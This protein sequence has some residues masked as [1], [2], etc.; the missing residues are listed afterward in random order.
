MKK[1]AKRASAKKHRARSARAK[2]VDRIPTG[3]PHFDA[4]IEG[5][6]EKR[7]TN[8]IVG[9]PGSGKSILA[10]Q[11][12][13]N[14]MMRGEHCLYITFEERKDE[15]YRNMLRFGWDL[16]EYEKRGLFTFLEYTPSKVR[17][18]LEEGGGII[19]SIV[20][21]KKVTRIVIDSIT[22][23]V[24][25]FEDELAKREASLKLFNMVSNWNCTSFLTLETN[26]AEKEKLDAR[27]MEFETDSIILLYFIRSTT[28]RERYLEVLKMRGTRHSK[29]MYRFHITDRGIVV[30]SSPRTKPPQAIR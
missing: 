28:Q 10:T 27:A 6:F 19:E 7:S 12:L 8:L 17:L 3:I 20:L 1:G 9:G 4:F 2:D 13:M 18:M 14:G 30:E 22:S 11:V 15:F 5:G 29:S 21:K 25:L 16:A 23:F 26:P 24:L